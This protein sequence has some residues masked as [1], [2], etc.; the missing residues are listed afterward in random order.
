M[1]AFTTIINNH[2]WILYL[3]GKPGNSPPTSSSLSIQLFVF[4]VAVEAFRPNN[5]VVQQ[6]DTQQLADL[7]HPP[8]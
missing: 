1:A 5:D 2:R 8:P 4:L 3:V 6:P 7:P